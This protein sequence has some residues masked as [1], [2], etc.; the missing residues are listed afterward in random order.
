MYSIIYED[1][2]GILFKNG[3]LKKLLRAGKHYIFT[4][5]G[6]NVEVHKLINDVNSKIA[7]NVLLENEEFKNAVD[8]I[9]INEYEICLYYFNEVRF[10]VLKSGKY[11]HW[12][13]PFNRKYVKIDLREVEISSDFDKSIFSNP[14][15]A[16]LFLVHQVEPYEVGLLVKSG[17][18]IRRLEQGRYFFWNQTQS[19]VVVYRIDLR[20]KNLEVVGQEILTLDRVTIR[21][22]CSTQYK[23]LDPEKAIFGMENQQVTLHSAVQFALREFTSKEKL[24]S[25]LDKKEEISKTVLENLKLREK[26]FGVEFI[27]SGI[28]D[29]ILPGEM[30]DILNTV[31][32]AEK[33]AQANII[34]RREEIASTRSLLNTAKLLDENKTLF[35]LKELEYLE[36]ISEKISSISISNQGNVLDQLSKLV[37]KE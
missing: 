21:L 7:V 24:D 15:M 4:W 27:N 35:R 37:G 8:V 22:N 10:E 3:K 30:K 19:P 6:E 12:K 16:G 20:L 23:I 33:K 13:S 17:K 9:D 18:F 11:V 28:K 25:L 5:L 31:L 36:K 34:T 14:K 32:L 29:I 1:E 26:E 2:I